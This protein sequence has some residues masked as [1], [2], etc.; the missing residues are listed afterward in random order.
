VDTRA[1]LKGRSHQRLLRPF[2]RRRISRSYAGPI[3]R[4][5]AEPQHRQSP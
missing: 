1:G 5:P 2:N 3:L 4:S